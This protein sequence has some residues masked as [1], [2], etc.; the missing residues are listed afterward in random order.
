MDS[1]QLVKLDNLDHLVITTTCIEKMITFYVEILRMEEVTFKEGRKALKFGSQKINLHE[2]RKEFSP[3]SKNPTPGSQDLCFLTSDPI[4]TWIHHFK[5]KKVC[6][7]EGPVERTGATGPTL[8]L[9]VRDPDQN[10]IEIASL[11]S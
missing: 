10:L 3:H 2:V 4:E 5:V 6:I 8:S 11:L 9:Y 7:E 1:K